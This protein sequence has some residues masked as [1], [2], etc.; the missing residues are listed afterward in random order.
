MLGSET[1]PLAALTQ[2]DEVGDEDF[3]QRDDTAAT[4]ALDAAADQKRGE[5]LGERTDYCTY[6]EEKEGDE[7]ERFTAEYVGERSKGGLKDSGG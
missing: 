1:E 7:E 6:R 2:R 4:D 5:I 3:S